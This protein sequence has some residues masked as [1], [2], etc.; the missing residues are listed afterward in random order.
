MTTTA[1][2]LG[3][4]AATTPIAVTPPARAKKRGPGGVDWIVL[5]LAII[6]AVV[7]AFPFLLILVN[8][9]KSPADY[10]SSGPLSLPTSLYLDGIVNFW[11]RVNFPEKLWNSVWISGAVALFAVLGTGLAAPSRTTPTRQPTRRP[12]GVAT[13]RGGYWRRAPHPAV[14]EEDPCRS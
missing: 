4:K 10:N 13:R 12:I 1:S 5:I 14:Q 2:E 11:N 7:I 8:S 6:G 3:V 9:F